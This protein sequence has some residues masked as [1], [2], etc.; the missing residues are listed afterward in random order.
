LLTHYPEFAT[1]KVLARISIAEMWAWLHGFCGRGHM[2]W[3][4]PE[5]F[6]SWNCGVLLIEPS[7]I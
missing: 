1:S 4:R 2:F 7:H 6:L 3:A 5:F